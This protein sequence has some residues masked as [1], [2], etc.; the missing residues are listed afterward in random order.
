VGKKHALHLKST[1]LKHYEITED[2]EGKK[3][4]GIDLEWNYAPE[5]AKRSCRIYIKNYIRDLLA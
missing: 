3:F 2:W 1:L 5:H 4:A